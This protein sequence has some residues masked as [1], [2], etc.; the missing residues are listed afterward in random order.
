MADP[1]LAADVQAVTP[2]YLDKGLYVAVLTPLFAIINQKWGFTLD[3]MALVAIMLPIVSYIVGHKWR[4]GT[5]AAAQVAAQAAAADP[6]P[7]LNA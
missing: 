4:S 2:F 7:K 5:I 6:G 3:P 1:I